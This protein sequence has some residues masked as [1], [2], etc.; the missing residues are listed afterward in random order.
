MP[1]ISAPAFTGGDRELAALG[2]AL[3]GPPAV[4]LAA[5]EAWIGKSRL[6]P[7]FLARTEGEGAT[8]WSRRARRSGDSAR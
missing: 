8:A 6:A 1:V 4:V 3:A 2:R 7:E 5:G